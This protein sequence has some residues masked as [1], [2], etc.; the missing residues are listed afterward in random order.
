L[1]NFH[2]G[3]ALPP[4]IPQRE[5][6]VNLRVDLCVPVL[7][8]IFSAQEKAKTVLLYQETRGVI[9]Q[10]LAFV[11]T[12]VISQLCFTVYTFVCFDFL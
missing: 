9:K 11:F 6:E 1:G 8:K 4:T 10:S 5:A 7:F 3:N 2:N 12:A